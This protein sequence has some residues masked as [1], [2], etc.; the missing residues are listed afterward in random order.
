MQNEDVND[1]SGHDGHNSF[2]NENL[3]QPPVV[4]NCQEY[5]NLVGFFFFDF[6]YPIV[7]LNLVGL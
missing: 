3:N 7:F 2:G 4:K 1:N 6:Y 5:K